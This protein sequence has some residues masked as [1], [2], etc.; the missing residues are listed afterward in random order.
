MGTGNKGTPLSLDIGKCMEHASK[1]YYSLEITGVRS[2]PFSLKRT[3]DE[4]EV[5][6]S[7]DSVNDAIRKTETNLKA[8]GQVLPDKGEKFKKRLEYLHAV[9]EDMRKQQ[10][11]QHCDHE[12]Y[13]G[14]A[15]CDS[16]EMLKGSSKNGN[17]V[18]EV[19]YTTNM[20][21]PSL[22]CRDQ[23]DRSHIVVPSSSFYTP[24]ISSKFDIETHEYRSQGSVAS[25]V[26]ANKRCRTLSPHKRKD[27]Y[28]SVGSSSVDFAR[29]LE[30]A[31]EEEGSLNL[32]SRSLPD[33]YRHNNGAS[34]DTAMELS[35][36]D[37]T[38]DMG[39]LKTGLKHKRISSSYDLRS[40]LYK[41]EG[42]RLTYPSGDPEAVEVQQ[43]D[44]KHLDD[45]E[46]LNDTVIDFY[47]KYLQRPEFLSQEKKRHFHFFN[48]FFFKKL[49]LDKRKRR[50]SD[51]AYLKL[52]NWTKGINIFQKSYLL[53]PIHDSAHWSLGIICFARNDD[54]ERD[55]DEE[56][57]VAPFILH[58]DSMRDGHASEEVFQVLRRYL[59]AE[60]NHVR[61]SGNRTI[62]LRDFVC[63]RVEV[64]LQQNA[65]DCGLFLLYFI[66]CF[67]RDANSIFRPS[68]LDSMFGRQ[69]FKPQDASNLRKNIR[70][71]LRNLVQK[72]N[73]EIVMEDMD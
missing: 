20:P 25:R 60:W 18:S 61:G 36:D 63:K 33:L 52:R 19:S 71:V 14:S 46:F 8:L 40:N 9:R 58:L 21:S 43:S 62:R 42:F 65:W 45:H 30:K 41:K 54:D 29:R 53:V 1:E 17:T 6:L 73:N 5:F 50:K 27:K 68:L 37:E 69:W 67:L 10:G 51:S 59:E 31:T 44:L 39:N 47:I 23:R 34:L 35:D 12:Q 49:L 28:P 55:D 70:S 11:L 56:D 32:K 2:D 64:P 13:K 24:N 3:E 16:I 15:F 66:E 48:T 72:L 57:D 26:A 4:E 22:R 38:N 7:I